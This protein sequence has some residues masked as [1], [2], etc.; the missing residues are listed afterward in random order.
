MV[1]SHTQRGWFHLPFGVFSLCLLGAAWSHSGTPTSTGLLFSSV[2]L[3]LITL[4]FAQLQVRSLEKSLLISFGP[5]AAFRR[6]VPYA[7]IRSVGVERSDFLDGLG[8]HWLPVRGWIWNIWGTRCVALELSGRRLRIGT[9]DPE[10]LV[11]FLE[12]QIAPQDV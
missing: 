10:G 11:T 2:V 5:L 12:G 8:I 9:D 3:G 4:S 1:Y 6:R 7:D